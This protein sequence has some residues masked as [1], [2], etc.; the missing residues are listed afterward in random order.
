MN[1]NRDSTD[2]HG[3]I[4][5]HAS[6]APQGAGVPDEALGPEVIIG[7]K[8]PVRVPNPQ[9]EYYRCV[10]YLRAFRTAGKRGRSTGTLI[11][12]GT[13]FGILTCA[14]A[15][16]DNAA[17]GP[18]ERIEFVPALTLAA[19]PYGVIS[20]DQDA[21]RIPDE[22]VGESTKAS[23]HDYAVI[24]LEP[25]QI[26]AGIGPLPTMETIPVDDL[27]EVQVTGYP[28]VPAPQPNPAMYYSQGDVINDPASTGL[29]RYKASTLKGSS[30]GGVCRV[31]TVEGA[32]VP[33]LEHITAVHVGGSGKA[34][35]NAGVYLTAEIIK[36]VREQIAGS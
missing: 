13:G 28:N 33:D 7:G 9:G 17:A 23:R 3:V 4:P 29:L 31:R 32:A 5:P 27:D 26:P 1:I 8:M 11:A 16:Y 12:A 36:W 20:A 15:V 21:I 14:H 10:G 25:N 6:T 30:G 19:Q 18:A 35:S 22:Y 24:R 2:P 34:Q